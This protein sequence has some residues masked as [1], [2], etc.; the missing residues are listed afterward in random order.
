LSVVATALV[1]QNISLLR[2]SEVLTEYDPKRGVS[3]ATLAYD[4]PSRFQVPEHAHGSDQ[5][6]YA[7]SGLM[8]V[9]SDQSKWFGA[10]M[11]ASFAMFFL[12]REGKIAIQRNYGCFDPL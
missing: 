4:Y 8:E 3:V 10:Q 5:L 6:I 1:R 2:Q 12:F 9:S 11:R 7:I